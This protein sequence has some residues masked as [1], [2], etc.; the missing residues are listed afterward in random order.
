MSGQKTALPL[1]TAQI[2]RRIPVLAN[3]TL[4]I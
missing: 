3:D 1:A 4:Y 2:T